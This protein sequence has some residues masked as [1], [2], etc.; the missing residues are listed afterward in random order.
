MNY[1]WLAKHPYTQMAK[2]VITEMNPQLTD[3]LLYNAKERLIT[4]LKKQ[5]EKIEYVSEQ[6]A[7][8]DFEKNYLIQVMELTQGNVSQAAKIAGKY[9]AD[10]YEL[11]EKYGLNPTDFRKG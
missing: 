8:D 3:E 6:Q 2:D 5:S 11:L 10:L 7:K 1:Q 9:R 4:L